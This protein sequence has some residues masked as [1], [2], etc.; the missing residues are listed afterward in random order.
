MQTVSTGR[1]LLLA[2]AGAVVVSVAFLATTPAGAA[3]TD[4]DLMFA[5]Q[6]RANCVLQ[7][8]YATTAEETATAQACIEI[9]DKVIAGLTPAPSSAAPSPST[10]PPPPPPPALTYP[11]AAT[12]GYRDGGALT[13]QGCVLAE[14]N[15]TYDH[16]VFNC[17]SNPGALVIWG[18]HITIKH[19]VVNAGTGTWGGVQVHPNA[20]CT[21]PDRAGCVVIEDT[22][23]QAAGSNPCAREAA[24]GGGDFTLSR[25]KVLSGGDGVDVEGSNITVRDSY[26]E[27]HPAG[28]AHSDGVQ[29]AGTGSNVVID[30]NTLTQ[31][32]TPSTSPVFWSGDVGTGV[33]VLNNLVVGGGYS[34]RFGETSGANAVV[35]GNVIARNEWGLRGHPDTEP[36]RDHTPGHVVR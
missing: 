18:H 1:A 3:S 8:A 24:V 2:A 21:L 20:G 9:Q 10:T 28:S 16:K 26:L 35:T 25:V 22:T 4:D 32:G 15:M 27:Q 33:R 6:A 5:R 11:T 30:H 7:V 12:T 31:R 19:S 14:D 13:T 23:V 36:L 29:L 17:G 34:I